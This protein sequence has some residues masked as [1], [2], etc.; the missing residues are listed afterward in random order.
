MT[1]HVYDNC[2]VGL[3]GVD[4]QLGY[5]LRT[6]SPCTNFLLPGGIKYDATLRRYGVSKLIMD[7]SRPRHVPQEL[8]HHLLLHTTTITMSNVQQLEKQLATK[9]YVD[10]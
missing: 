9:S 5:V 7:C 4:E 8:F 3:L 6:K 1:M 10:G 2:A